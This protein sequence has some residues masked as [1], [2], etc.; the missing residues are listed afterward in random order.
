MDAQNKHCFYTV[1]EDQALTEWKSKYK[2]GVKDLETLKMTL[3]AKMEACYTGGKEIFVVNKSSSY[4]IIRCGICK[5]YQ[6][7]LTLPN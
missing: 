1:G 6:I 5:K 2:N 3:V 7:W 4:V